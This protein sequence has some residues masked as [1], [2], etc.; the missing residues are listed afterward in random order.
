LVTVA[1]TLV[2]PA[3][4]V[5]PQHARSRGRILKVIPVS[6]MAKLPDCKYKGDA[7]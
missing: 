5:V 2:S 6:K 3:M 7:V 4:A 1:V